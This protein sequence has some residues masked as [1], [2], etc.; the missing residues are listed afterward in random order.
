MHI[1]RTPF[2]MR[3]LWPVFLIGIAGPALIS[4]S[5]SN[6][7]QPESAR[8]KRQRLLSSS[9]TFNLNITGDSTSQ[10][11]DATNEI[12]SY[13]WMAQVPPEQ[14]LLIS[15]IGV[16]SEVTTRVY[17][18]QFKFPNSMPG[19]T[20]NSVEFSV[21]YR[22]W[23]TLSIYGSGELLYQSELIGSEAGPAT[24]SPSEAESILERSKND[25]YT[26]FL[27]DLCGSLMQAFPNRLPL[28]LTKRQTDASRACLEWNTNGTGQER[29][30]EAIVQAPSSYDILSRA[31]GAIAKDNSRQ[32]EA[33]FPRWLSH[34]SP[35]VQRAA[36]TKIVELTPEDD[37]MNR[38]SGSR[39]TKSRLASIRRM[40]W[41]LDAL[42]QAE[43]HSREIL[44]DGLWLSV[45]AQIYH[46]EYGGNAWRTWCQL[47]NRFDDAIRIGLQDELG[48]IRGKVVGYE[49]D[50][51]VCRI[52]ETDDDPDVRS[53][54]EYSIDA[55]DYG[56]NIPICSCP[57]NPVACLLDGR[58]LGDAI[59]LHDFIVMIT[60]LPRESYLING[61]DEEI[62]ALMTALGRSVGA[63][64]QLDWNSSDKKE[65]L[66]YI[67]NSV[68][69]LTRHCSPR[70]RRLA[71]TH[72]P[73]AKL[74][75]QQLSE[76]DPD[77]L[78]RAI[79]NELLLIPTA[80]GT[81]D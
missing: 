25:A 76:R 11:R 20:G 16:E 36:A 45:G 39:L 13:F 26:E 55:R 31:I 74:E 37:A 17:S 2:T 54:A 68:R 52:A 79:A 15:E 29:V 77:R 35:T 41:M 80:T 3:I 21:G 51:Q 23:G 72:M 9:D 50:P 44:M 22:M 19:S 30:I 65:A 33:D 42:P 40:H 49:T 67:N 61:S 10:M 7:V 6:T 43:A 66:G 58:E 46:A 73:V 24:L 78:I 18:E 28:G 62:A 27:G 34:S 1:D 57:D 56:R 59:G 12:F 63:L 47:Q 70:I 48:S 60:S 81:Q 5:A 71:L 64:N 14:A 32:F 69:R 4:C 8:E 53:S 75:L 38:R